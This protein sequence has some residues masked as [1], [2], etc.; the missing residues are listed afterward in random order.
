MRFQFTLR[1][2]MITV[3]VFA[4]CLSFF[5]TC[6]PLNSAAAVLTALLITLPIS[7][8]TLISNKKDFF[9]VFH[10]FFVLFLAIC[11]GITGRILFDFVRDGALSE[12]FGEFA[13]FVPFT[14]MA[15][16]AIVADRI[17][18]KC[19]KHN[20]RPTQTEEL[21]PEDRSANEPNTTDPPPS[22]PMN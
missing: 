7:I 8:I 4:V 21:A 18:K 22:V 16:C 20:P 1:R 11:G 14:C 3:T 5:S 10:L 17:W 15:V 6:T 12:M 9:N 13:I 2:L 19:F